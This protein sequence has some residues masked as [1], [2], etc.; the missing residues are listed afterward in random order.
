[1]SKLADKECVACRGDIPAMGHEEQQRLLKDLKGWQVVDSHHLTK[2]Y[3][4]KDFLGALAWVNKVGAIAEDV[5]HHPNIS[6]TWGKVNISIWTHKVNG[7]TESDFIL[8]AKL[9]RAQA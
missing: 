4:F 3:T 9:D 2:D 8:A 7:L 6:F 1:M 5:G